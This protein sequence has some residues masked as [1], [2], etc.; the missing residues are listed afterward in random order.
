MEHRHGV[1]RAGGLVLVAEENVGGRLPG[2]GSEAFGEGVELAG[3]IAAVATQ[4]ITTEISRGDIWRGQGVRVGYAKGGVRGA[5]RV[6]DGFGE[7]AG[8]TELKGYLG[9]RGCAQRGC[10]QEG[11]EAREVCLEVGWKLEEDRTELARVPCGLEGSEETVELVPAFAQAR[12]MGDA[13][14]SLEAEAEAGRSRREPAFQLGARGQGA[15]GVVDLHR[16]KL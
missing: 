14:R 15:E 8:M 3:E 6:V 12:E 7:P 1:K 13:L 9:G 16:G 10:L 11:G 2:E 4:A 5:Q